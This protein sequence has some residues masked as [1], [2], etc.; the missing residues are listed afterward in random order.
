MPVFDINGVSSTVE[1]SLEL[2]K[3]VAPGMQVGWSGDALPFPMDL[4]DEPV[5]GF[6]GNYGSVPIEVGMG[7]NLRGVPGSARPHRT[8]RG[9]LKPTTSAEWEPQTQSFAWRGEL[10]PS[11]PWRFDHFTLPERT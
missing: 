11:I 3:K 8:N 5:R 6:L 7:G 9:A 2:L 10:P 4:S 1:R